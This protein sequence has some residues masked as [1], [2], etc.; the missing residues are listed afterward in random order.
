MGCSGPAQ[1]FLSRV[2]EE[3]SVREDCQGDG[4][5]GPIDDGAPRA[6]P[7]RSGGSRWR[8]GVVGQE[9]GCLL[10]KGIVFRMDIGIR[11][12]AR[13]RAEPGEEDDEQVG[14]FHD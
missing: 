3:L 1:E 11:E 14:T 10:P 4:N 5:V 2:G 12:Q 13:E 6:C 8:G 9:R 7:C